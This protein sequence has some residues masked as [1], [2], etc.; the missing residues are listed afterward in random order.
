MVNVG[1]LWEIFIVGSL[2]FIHRVVVHRRDEA[3]RGWRSWLREDLLVHPDKWLRPDLV[4][5]APFLQCERNLRTV[6]LVSLLIQL[7][8]MRNS[9]RPGF[10]I[11]VAQG[12]PALR[13]SLLK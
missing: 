11:F 4:L 2:I 6:V 5:P 8:L 1:V 3:I 9:E 10:P 7:G 12:R 13:N